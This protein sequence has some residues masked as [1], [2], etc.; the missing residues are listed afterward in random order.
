MSTRFTP[1]V[2]TANDL[3]EGDVIYLTAAGD[4]SRTHTDAV[5]F[6]D[7]QTAE[8]VLAQATG[9][10][11]RLVGAYLAPARHGPNGPEPAHFREAFRARGPSNYPHGKQAEGLC[12]T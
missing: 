2:V 9:Q 3:F 4:W 7:P 10:A 6:T 11:D 8:A 12:R 1:S 5:L